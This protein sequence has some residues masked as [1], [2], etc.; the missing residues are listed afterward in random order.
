MS[1]IKRHLIDAHQRRL[2]YLRV[3]ITDRC[4]LNCIYCNPLPRAAKLRH[5]EILRYEEILRIARIGAG[6]GI[7]KIRVTGGEPLARKGVGDF[8]KHLTAI[9]G[10]RE[11]SLTT[12]GV[13]LDEH[14]ADIAAAGIRRLNISLDTLDRRVYHHITGHDAFDRVWANIRLA[15][16]MGFSPI[17]INVVALRSVNE[18]E[19]KALARLALNYPFHVRFI[20]YMPLGGEGPVHGHP[21]LLTPEIRTL[22]ESLGPLTPIPQVPDDGP[23]MRYRFLEGSGEIGFISPVSNHF[24]AACNRL[25]LTSD[26]RLLACLLA[27]ISEDIKTPLRLGCLDHDLAAAFLRIVAKKPLSHPATLTPSHQPE[28]MISIGG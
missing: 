3:S 1:Q 4:N 27:N 22:I 24:C 16:E 2:N 12:N 13:L 20:E 9:P 11:C 6:L 25:R 8:L 17:K 19:L 5:K 23:A 14:I 7:T 21:P 26:G 10:I 18:G 15:L 28:Q